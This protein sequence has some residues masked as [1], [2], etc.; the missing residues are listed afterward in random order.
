[1]DKRKLS[2]ILAFILAVVAVVLVRNYIAQTERK[3][4]KE[5]KKAF[6]VVATANIPAGTTIDETMVRFEGI[7]EKYVQPKA[8]SSQSLVVGKRAMADIFAGEQIMATKLTLAV[9]DTSLAMR[10]PQG[11]RAMTITIPFL[12]AVGGKVR[13]GDYVDVVGIFPYNAQVDGKV[14]TELVS[15]TLF[16]NILILGVEGAG[17]IAARGQAAPAA[18]TDLIVTL[19]LTPKEIAML[20]YAMDQGKLKLVL[21]P[22]LE[23]A[24]EPVPPVEANAMWQY[25]FSSLGQEF[26]TGKQEPEKNQPASLP[27]QE[28]KKEPPPPML[29]VYRGTERTSMV[30][31]K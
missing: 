17:G 20:I 4:V 26:V 6:V 12:S 25:V 9:K 31:N 11:K 27:A 18:S 5:E 16:Q 19:A 24:I 15:V 2:I 3:F 21:R 7:P 30:L 23:T 28:E 22:P 10:T 1:M 14:V 8:I 29:E 13:P